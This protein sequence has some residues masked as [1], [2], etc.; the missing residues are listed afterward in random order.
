MMRS[1][2]QSRC[3]HREFPEGPLPLQI[4]ATSWPPANEL[5]ACNDDLV[6]AIIEVIA[7]HTNPSRNH[8]ISSKII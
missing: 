3:L 2:T 4:E 8:L 5:N 6:V 7:E 1:M